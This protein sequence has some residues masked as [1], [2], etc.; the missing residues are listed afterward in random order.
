LQAEA[1]ERVVYAVTKRKVGRA[2][3][4]VQI[5]VH[6]HETAPQEPRKFKVTV[7]RQN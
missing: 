5:M 2:V 6:S 4:P 3:K 1:G 7:Q